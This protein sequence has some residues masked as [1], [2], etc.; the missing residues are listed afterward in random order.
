[1]VLGEQEIEVK[2]HN[3]ML[4]EG[5][6]LRD[7]SGI[8]WFRS[9]KDAEYALLWKLMKEEAKAGQCISKS[10]RDDEWTEWLELQ[11]RRT[12]LCRSS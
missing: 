4:P 3:S 5:Y 1:M 10:F 6:H 7:Q 12:S 2:G 11:Q 8:A 9:K